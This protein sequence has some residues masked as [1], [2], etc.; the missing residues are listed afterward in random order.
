MHLTREAQMLLDT[1]LVR[2][3]RAWSQALVPLLA[4]LVI[5]FSDHGDPQEF[6]KNL[7][8]EVLDRVDADLANTEDA[9][10]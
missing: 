3:V 4:A 2:D 9:T 1:I 5:D 8:R 7:T 10:D 6:M